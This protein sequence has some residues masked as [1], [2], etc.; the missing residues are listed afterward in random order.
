MAKLPPMWLAYIAT[1]FGNAVLIYL[2]WHGIYRSPQCAMP[3][4]QPRVVEMSPAPVVDDAAAENRGMVRGFNA[5]KEAHHRCTEEFP[6]EGSTPAE[7]D[8]DYRECMT[9]ELMGFGGETMDAHATHMGDRVKM[10]SSFSVT[11]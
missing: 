4:S 9:I 11:P 3:P 6:P 10:L 2:V 8:S 1:L 5:W 7:N